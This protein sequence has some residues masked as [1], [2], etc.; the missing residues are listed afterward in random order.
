MNWGIFSLLAVI[1]RRARGRRRILHLPGKRSARSPRRITVPRR[2]R[3]APVLGRSDLRTLG[4][5][6]FADWAVRTAVPKDGRTPA[7]A[8]GGGARQ[9]GPD[10]PTQ[11]YDGKAFRIAARGF[12]AGRHVDALIIYMHWLMI[13]LFVG[14]LGLLCLRADPLPPRAQSPGGLPRRPE[15]RFELPRRR[16]GAGRGSPADLAR[17]SALGQGGG[18][19]SPQRANP[20]SSMSS[21]SSLIGTPSMPGKD[22]E[23]GRQDMHFV[24]ATNVFGLDP[25]DPRS[26][27]DVQVNGLG[28]CKCR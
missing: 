17:H 7:A 13:A 24:R 5:G 16:G 19:V 28:E 6:T 10:Q 26:K 25:G 15:P 12:G 2:A 4:L 20:R 9:V 8:L 18:P 27:D 21:A 3:G 23:F 1:G 22:G 14:W 11:S